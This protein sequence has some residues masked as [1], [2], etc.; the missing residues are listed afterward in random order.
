MSNERTSRR[1]AKIAAKVMAMTPNELRWAVTQDATAVLRDI[2]ALSTSV[3]AQ[4]PSPGT[5]AVAAD[6][7]GRPATK[8]RLVSVR[9]P[10]RKARRSP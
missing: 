3:L 8:H 9:K 4:A 2:R 5:V 10:R 7:L 6:G 1:V